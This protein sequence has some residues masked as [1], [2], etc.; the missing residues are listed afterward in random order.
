MFRQGKALG[1]LAEEAECYVLTERGSFWIHLI[2]NY[3]VLN[4]ID[5]LWTRAIQEPWPGRIEL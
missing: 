3:Y 4:Y 1:M 5:K 2:Q